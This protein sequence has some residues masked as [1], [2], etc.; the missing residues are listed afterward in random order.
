M[1]EAVERSG[2]GLL[3]V[4]AANALGK[5]FGIVPVPRSFP[6]PVSAQV[7]DR[8]AVFDHI[9]RANFWGSEESRSGL[10]SEAH[11]ARGFAKRLRD[12]L[13][14]EKLSRIVDA[15]CGDLNWVLGIARDPGI[16]YRGGDISTSLIAELQARSPDLALQQFDI[17]TDAFPE[18]DVWLC[19]DCLFHLPFA[20]IRRALQNFAGSRIPYALLTTHLARLLRNLDVPAGGFRYLD[21]ERAPL[22][23]P[24]ARRYLKDFRVGRD[25]PRYVGLWSRADIASACERWS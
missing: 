4:R 22:N 1:Q 7:E 21:L 16:A 5:P 18:A 12:C 13:E 8:S 9:Y 14:E 20:D 2:L 11:Y 15:P 3:A 10:G 17:C 25:F 24:P 23:L 6:N 19:R